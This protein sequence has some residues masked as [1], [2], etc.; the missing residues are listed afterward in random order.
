VQ[1]DSLVTLGNIEKAEKDKMKNKI[2]KILAYK[3]DVFINR[4]LI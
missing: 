1:T 2:D 4:Q 3:P